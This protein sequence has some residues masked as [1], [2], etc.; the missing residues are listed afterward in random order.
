MSTV[1]EASLQR[2]P[3]TRVWVLLG[4]KAGDNTQVLALA[5]RLGWSFEQKYIVHR[6]WE[7]LANRLLG[8]TLAGIDRKRSSPLVSPWPDLVISSGRRNEPV[9]RWIQRQSGGVCRTV[10]VGRPWA[11]PGCFDLLV[12]TPQYPIAGYPNVLM[13]PLPMHRLDDAVL[14]AARARW[15]SRFEA[16]PRPR[17]VVLLGGNS[18]AF[19]FTKAKARRLGAMVNGLVRSRGGSVLV[20]DSA[21]TP[22][23]VLEAF[24]AEL[25]VPV[26][27][28]RWGGARDLNTYPGYLATADQFVVTA[29]S[30]S[31]VAEAE[32]TG[33]P[34]YLFSLDD[35]PDWWKR[36]YNYR[37]D[38]LMHRLAACVGPVRLRRDAEAMMRGLVAEGRAAWLGQGEPVGSATRSDDTG[39]AA[40]AVAALFTSRH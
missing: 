39:V 29:D 1:S 38:A 11:D 30:V 25:K 21:R 35:G 2:T 14:S 26:H 22:A 9:A 13:N 37:F 34:V 5:E 33:K 31:M 23:G 18:G 17:T 16:L 4:R 36:A 24:V 12:A 19:V 10:H 27:A 8:V 32:C 40:T 28:H 15:E 6:S 7:L 20:T 3:P